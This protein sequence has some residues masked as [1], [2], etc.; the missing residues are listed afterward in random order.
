MAYSR[1][2]HSQWYV[3]WEAP[4]GYV[5][6]RNNATVAV[7][8]RDPSD[9]RVDEEEQHRFQAATL[10]KDLSKCLDV[11][12]GRATN[13]ALF[14]LRE[15]LLLFLKDVEDEYPKKKRGQK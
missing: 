1:F 11:F 15:Y 5:L 4:N 3:Y 6:N 7:W 8:W 13:S 2:Y 12:S 10:R 9:Q 14:E